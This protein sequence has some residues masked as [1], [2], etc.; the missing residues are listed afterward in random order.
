MI[1]YCNED[2]DYFVL[3]DYLFTLFRHTPITSATT[4]TTTQEQ[5]LNFTTIVVCV[6][7]AIKTTGLQ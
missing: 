4:I 5:Y 7:K 3:R 2:R 6:G 1:K